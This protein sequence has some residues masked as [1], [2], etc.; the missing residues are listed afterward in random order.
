M[1]ALN[2]VKL[3]AVGVGCFALGYLTATSQPRSAA[4]PMPPTKAVQPF[5]M[6]ARLSANLYQQ[7]AAEYQACCLTIYRSAELRLGTILQ[8]A[9]PKP[10]RPAIVMDLDETVLDNSK[11]QSFLYKYR[12]EY[13]DALWDIYEGDYPKDVGLVPGAKDLI[14]W[15]ERRG[16]AVVYISN[17]SEPFRDGTIAALR[18][19]GLN[20]ADID[21]RLYL[22]Q[23]GGTSDKSSR[24]D[25]VSARFNVLMYFGDNLRDF[26][27]VFVAPKLPKDAKA[28]AYDEAIQARFTAV[29]A[30]RPRWGIDWFMLPNPV[31]GEWEKLLGDDP[32]ARLRPTDI[33]PPR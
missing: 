20:V 14:E 10:E 33:V 32:K 2:N 25:A 4:D 12:L 13:T 28:V 17:R 23:K 27:E 24:R 22:K 7:T 16:V 15:A 1:P 26:A 18:H 30:A 3:L 8:T 6:E 21:E 31:Y 9:T 29:N 11:F 5:P 19:N